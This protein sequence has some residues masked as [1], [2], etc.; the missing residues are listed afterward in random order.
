MVEGVPFLEKDYTNPRE[1]VDG[2]MWGKVKEAEENRRRG[3]L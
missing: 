2:T 1:M 3:E